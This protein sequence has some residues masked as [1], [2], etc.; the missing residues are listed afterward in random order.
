MF[1]SE[2]MLS[3]FVMNKLSSQTKSNR[4]VCPQTRNALSA[5]SRYG[6]QAF[7]RYFVVRT[8]ISKAP[9]IISKASSHRNATPASEFIV[10]L[11]EGSA[12]G[13]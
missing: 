9:P 3:F 5:I 6:N 12:K 2:R 13:E 7:D 10:I 11:L 4:T 8:F 1:F